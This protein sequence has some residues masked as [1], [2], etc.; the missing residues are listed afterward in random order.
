MYVIFSKKIC[1][2]GKF[3]ILLKTLLGF[4][5]PPLDTQQNV[6]AMKHIFS[7]LS[8]LDKKLSRFQ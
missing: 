3:T 8:P 2:F 5:M 7:F 4:L 6:M 1:T